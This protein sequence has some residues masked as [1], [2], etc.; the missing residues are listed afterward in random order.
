MKAVLTIAGHDC[1]NGAGITKDLEVFAS[2]GLHG[3]SVPTCS[4]IQGPKGA[5]GLA[6]V[7]DDLFDRMLRRVLEDFPLSGVKIGILPEA[8][9]VNRLLDLLAPLKTVVILDPVRSAKNGLTLM[10]DGARRVIEEDL[11]PLLTCITPNL[12]EA[13]LLTDREIG[14]LQGMEWAARELVRKGAKTAVVK[15]GHLA[16]RPVDLLFDGSRVVTYEKER[17]DRNVHGTGCLFS[18]IL[19]SFLVLGYEIAEAFEETE[20][21]V[22]EL[23]A[24]SEQPV[25]GGYFYASPVRLAIRKGKDGGHRIQ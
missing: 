13:S 23:L 2:L 20:K 8:Y 24:E 19:L 9:H 1:S 16:G 22:G 21:A 3:L 15:G 11:L 14:D 17:I 7:S 25:A 12:D 18:S 5:T 10:T 4:V 6:P